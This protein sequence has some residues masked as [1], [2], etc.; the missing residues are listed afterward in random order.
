MLFPKPNQRFAG[1]WSG[2]YID[3]NIYTK[4]YKLGALKVWEQVVAWEDMSLYWYWSGIYIILGIY[5]Y[6]TQTLI[7]RKSLKNF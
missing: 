2:I 7:N 1:Y 3:L 5:L 4:P 6:V